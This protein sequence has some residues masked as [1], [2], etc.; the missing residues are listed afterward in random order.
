MNNFLSRSKVATKVI[1]N[2]I[3]KTP[4]EYNKRLSEKYNCNLYIK[5]E[6]LNQGRSFK[7]RGAYN[8]I[9][10]LSKAIKYKGIVCASAGN[11]AQG[12]AYTCNNLKINNNIFIPEKTPLQKVNRIKYFGGDRCKIN[13]IGKNFNESLTYALNYA[14][15]NN[16]EF[17]HPFNDEDVIIGQSTIGE[18]IYQDMNPDII[19]GS[20][21]GGGMLSGISLYC[22]YNKKKC[23]IIG[24]EPNTCDS[25]NQS[26]INNKLVNLEIKD[27]FVDGATV[28]QVGDLTF[29]ICKE[30][31]KE[32]HV[33]DV[34]N[35]CGKILDLYQDDGI[36]AEPAGALPF[37]ILD[38]ISYKI[39]NKT[40]V[41]ILSGGNNDLTRY[42]EILERYYQ[43]LGLKQYYLIEFAQTPG[44]LKKFIN[45]IL[46]ETDDISRFEY[47]KKTNKEYG[48]V[49]IGIQ[50]SNT[51][52]ILKIDKELDKHNFRYIKINDND[53]LYSYLI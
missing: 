53:L 43:Y 3:K 39:K 30:H 32:I 17:I 46:K 23:D 12:V 35:V 13:L 29:K 52:D 31:L 18:E 8:K 45:T 26:I 4:L 48:N 16:K 10:N 14:K 24:V 42:P 44:Q 9:V 49:L 20:I 15:E 36:I 37:S 38:E 34:G 51:S 27:N 28:S 2:V 11:H 41:C 5:R 33:V 47:I 40:V 50:V 22:K 25:M 21:G 19:I 7:I 6:D 1:Q